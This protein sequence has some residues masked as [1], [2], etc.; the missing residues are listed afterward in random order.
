MVLPSAS[1][2]PRTCW[3]SMT[4]RSTLL[5]KRISPPSPVIVARMFSTILTS[6]KVP[7]CGLLTTMI[8]SGAPFAELPVGLGIQLVLAPQAPGVLGPFAHRLAALKDD[9]PEAHLGQDQPGEQAAGA[10]ADDDRAGLQFSRRLGD[11][12][13]AGIRRR[14]DVAIIGKP[15]E[16][17]GL[18]GHRE[19]Q[20]IDQHDRRLLARVVAAL[21]NREIEQFAVGDAQAPAD[22][23]AQRIGGVVERQLQFSQSQHAALSALLELL[24]AGFA[25]FMHLIVGSFGLRLVLASGRGQQR[26]GGRQEGLFVLFELLGLLPYLGRRLG[27]RVVGVRAEMR[28]RPVA[29]GQQAFGVLGELVGVVAV[30]AQ[31]YAHRL[32]SLDDLLERRLPCFDRL[33]GACVLDLAAGSQQCYGREQKKAKFER[34]EHSRRSSSGL[35]GERELYGLSSPAAACDGKLRSCGYHHLI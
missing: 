34:L 7:M 33:A 5:P 15:G 19:V 8:S 26:V 1:T 9:W 28:P 24:V 23:R 25:G 18:V 13:V 32:E 4:R 2:T 14:A 6:R 16:Q 22:R 21:E 30:L 35:A 20:G 11:E 10:G 3:S 17:R 27:R 12:L 31:H 29:P